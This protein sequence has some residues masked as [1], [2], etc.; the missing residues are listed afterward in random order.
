MNL[1][2][3]IAAYFVVAALLGVSGARGRR[4][5]LPLSLLPFLSQLLFVADEAL[6]DDRSNRFETIEWLPA[7]G[8]NLTIR[9]DAMTLVLTGVVATIGLL[10]VAYSGR[11][12]TDGATRARF[13][14]LMLL[15]TGG[16]AGLVA[17][18]ELFGL[19][20]FWEV[21][22]VA[23]YLLIGFDDEKAAARAA[24]V[25]AVLVTTAGGLAMLGGFVLLGLAAD[26]T[27]IAAIVASPPE[28]TTVT[29]ALGL[30]FLGAFT[31]SAQFPFHFWLPGAMAAP[32]PASAYLHS[33]TMVKA[34]I[35]LLL[36][37]APGFADEPIWAGT[38]TTI[39][40]VT[41]LLGAVQALR[42]HDLK[43]LLAHGTVSQLGFIVA[44]IGVGLTGPALAVLVAHAAFKATL[45]L[46][47]GIIDKK[48]G[49]RDIRHLAGIRQ[50]SPW[51]AAVA[52]L[53]AL[54]MAGIIPLIGFV[55]KEAAFDVLISDG[56]W[57]TLIGTALGSMLTVGYTARFWW[58]A[59]EEQPGGVDVSRLG[60]IDH[61]LLLPPTILAAGSLAFGIFPGSIGAAVADATEQSVKLVLWPGFK[62]ALAVSAVVIAGGAL[63]HLLT[64]SLRSRLPRWI[65]RL[66]DI[67][68]P[69]AQGTYQGAVRGL[70]RVAD[71]VTGVV[72][73][74]SLPVYLAVILATLFLVPG[75]VW[76][77]TADATPSWIVANS[78]AE[79]VLA[80]AA[81]TAAVA[82]TRVTRRMAAALLLGAV[83]FAVSGIYVAFGAPDLALTQLL[84]E[85]FTVALFAFVL[86]RLPRRFGADPASLSR[87]IRI[88]LSVLAGVFVTVAALLA[89]STDADRTAARFYA[90]N[91]EAAGGRNVVNVILTD[92]RAL[93]TLG[94][95][96]VLAA[97]AV[98]IA[99]LV[100]AGRSRRSSKQVDDR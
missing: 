60:A 80:V 17:T 69:T 59:F 11:Y 45:F 94:E 43:L 79:V 35:V 4:I 22:T 9:I 25:Q 31:K 30:I 39:G 53:A 68:L 24:A 62:P 84:I 13:I 33:A 63:V 75:T 64:H 98:G 10:I 51:L 44:L 52:A 76:L 93:D 55:T 58:G 15:F 54:S 72:Q 83:G 5:A 70:N 23:S 56:R 12:F 66:D 7:L 18:D 32:T 86:S 8:V 77:V 28:G 67:S 48:T 97:A 57:P 46:V 3:T 85:T 36:L 19:F 95:I 99:A 6:A 2:F 71:T 100:G 88:G 87:R 21:T 89:T 27:S 91:A 81:V 37:L 47:V 16:M 42:Q 82:A 96:T 73:N 29:V 78:A 90:D 40:I 74:G 50:T 20:I 49:T 14:A 26:T 34:G 1:A 61:F 65:H 38:V 41:M 92:F